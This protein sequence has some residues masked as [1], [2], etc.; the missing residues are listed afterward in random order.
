MAG[1]E[2]VGMFVWMWDEGRD[3]RYF[4]EVK[5][6]LAGLYVEGS[7]DVRRAI[8]HAVIEHLFERE[9]IR[10]FFSDWRDD[11]RLRP[12]YDEGMLWVAGGGTSPLTE[13]RMR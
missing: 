7:S 13:R 6:R 2:L 12:A 11:P 1:T 4:V 10:E 9:P 8:E 5:S 3:R